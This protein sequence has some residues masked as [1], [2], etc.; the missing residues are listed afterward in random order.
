MRRGDNTIKGVVLQNGTE[1]YFSAWK[2][3]AI[4]TGSG[5]TFAPEDFYVLDEQGRR[6]EFFTWDEAMQLEREILR[7]NGWRLSTLQDWAKVGHEFKT[8]RN[9]R[10]KLHLGLNGLIWWDKMERCNEDP[11]SVTTPCAW[12]DYGFYWSSTMINGVGVYR[13]Y[14]DDSLIRPARSSNYR[15]YGS[16]VRCVAQ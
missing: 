16:S 2:E 10:E 6:K 9:I 7:P 13:L 8:S 1:T 5:I 15:N 4:H 11:D 3:N 12:G 14:L